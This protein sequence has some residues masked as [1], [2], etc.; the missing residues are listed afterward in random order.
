MKAGKYSAAIAKA[1]LQQPLL[2]EDDDS[3]S[4]FDSYDR[5]DPDEPEAKLGGKNIVQTVAATVL[6]TGGLAAAASAMIAVPSAAVLVMGGICAVNAPTVAGKHFQISKGEG[7]L[8]IEASSSLEN[9]FQGM[10]RHG[11]TMASHCNLL[12]ISH[13]VE[14]CV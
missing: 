11:P 13:L 9:L 2:V 4:T 1:Q 7:E 12:A 14:C 3:V 6:A 8:A 10:S 5:D